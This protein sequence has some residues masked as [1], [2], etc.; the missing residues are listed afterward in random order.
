MSRT[1]ASVLPFCRQLT[2]SL[3]KTVPNIALMWSY[4]IKLKQNCFVSVC[5]SFFQLAAY[6]SCY[7]TALRLLNVSKTL[8]LDVLM[9]CKFVIH[10]ANAISIL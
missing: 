2:N 10:C 9:Y 7:Y 5:F 4:E 6:L 8:T 1:S 3:R